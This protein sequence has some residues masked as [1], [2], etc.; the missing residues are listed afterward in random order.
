MTRA[1]INIA[2]AVVV[3]TAYAALAFGGLLEAK[4]STQNPL[5]ASSSFQGRRNLMG[6][7][8]VS[9]TLEAFY[10]TEDEGLRKEIY[11]LAAEAEVQPEATADLKSLAVQLWANFDAF[12]VE[13]LEEI[14][15]DEWRSRGL[16]FNDN[17]DIA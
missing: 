14:L 15:R 10:M 1:E 6:Q 5:A 2:V 3:L 7:W 16:P 4:R 12:S 9:K 8:R 13:D 11:R 17:S